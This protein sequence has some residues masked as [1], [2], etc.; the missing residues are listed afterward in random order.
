MLVSTTK[1]I[2]KHLPTLITFDIDNVMP[3]LNDI[4]EEYVQRILGDDLYN[5]L[6]SEYED[7]LEDPEGH[8]WD[9]NLKNLLLKV[10]GF[11]VPLAF[12]RYTP[13][14]IVHA[15][16]TG[17]QVYNNGESMPANKWMVDRITMQYMETGYRRMESLYV[18]L[19]KKIEHYPDWENSESYTTFTSC[20][21]R[22]VNEFENYVPIGNSRHTLHRIMSHINTFQNNVAEEMEEG[23]FQELLDK[24]VNND[25]DDADK[26]LVN[27]IR[28]YVANKAMEFGMNELPVVFSSYGPM[29]YENAQGDDDKFKQ[30]S[31]EQL[32]NYT[33]Q[34]RV[35]AADFWNRFKN[36]IDD[37]DANPQFRSVNDDLNHICGMM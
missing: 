25:L 22:T 21:F 33:N 23:T 26:K 30:K 16:Q 32:Q 3:F 14:S 12:Y 18:F 31:K 29:V 4:E 6:I 8:E 11:M 20:I 27:A 24:I 28:G 13:F 19:E 7:Y 35:I 5:S 36:L 10:Q 2:Q 9:E 15:G 37:T 17:L 1:E 34:R